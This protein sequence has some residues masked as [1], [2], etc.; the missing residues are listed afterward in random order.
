[1]PK[2]SGF[3]LIELL[4]VISIIAIL[5]VVGFTSFTNV[6]KGAR[7]AKRKADIDSIAKAYEVKYDSDNSQYKPLEVTAFTSGNIPQDPNAAKGYYYNWLDKDKSGF[8]LCASLEN[9]G[10]VACTTSA[11]SC[12][13]KDSTQGKVKLSPIVGAYIDTA[14]PI[15]ANEA[16]THTDLGH[17]SINPAPLCDT[18]VTL[19]DRLVG[20]WKMDEGNWSG[21]GAVKDSSGYSN[22]G[23][24]FGGA[25]ITTDT[26]PNHNSS[27]NFKNVGSFDGIDG[28]VR[29]RDNDSLDVGTGDFTIAFWVKPE[30]LI[31][32]QYILAKGGVDSGCPTGGARGY[33]L[34]I[35]STGKVQL[36]LSTASDQGCYTL[37]SLTSPLAREWNHVAAVADRDGN[38]T[39]YLNG[40]DNTPTLLSG[41][42]NTLNNTG[43]FYIGSRDS[44]TAPYKGKIDDVRIYNKAL[45]PQE[46]TAL[47]N[48]GNGC[49]P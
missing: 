40:Q 2:R 6:Q 49:I 5:S 7:D 25:A 8:R 47:Y 32:N 42:S 12:Y 43:D 26:D 33:G 4:V 37:D 20:Y 14:N 35:T 31:A 11:S 16:T 27:S 18:T 1:M 15:Y 24:A 41:H 22:D 17:G 23:T 36:K 13:C 21:S 30:N 28:Y 46:V 3:T 39:I 10:N 34:R 48:G 29:V 44:A 38:G 19:T 45:S 9:N